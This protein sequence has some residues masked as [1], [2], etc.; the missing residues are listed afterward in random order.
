MHL[1]YLEHARRTQARDAYVANSMQAVLGHWVYWRRSDA[2][3]LR[4]EPSS[5][6][7]ACHAGCS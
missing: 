3:D 2:Y 7:Y 1:R 6:A 5:E 4:V